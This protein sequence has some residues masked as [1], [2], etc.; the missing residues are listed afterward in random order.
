M[1]WVQMK[2]DYVGKV[3]KE[4]VKALKGVKQRF[5]TWST[6]TPLDCKVIPGGGERLWSKY[7]HKQQFGAQASYANHSSTA[8]IIG[9]E[10]F[11][12]LRGWE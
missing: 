4:E 8:G 10:G 1:P 12:L 3:H 11:Q 6:H 2:V 7:R 5:L 9:V